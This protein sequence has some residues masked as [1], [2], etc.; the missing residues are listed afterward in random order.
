MKY[1][2]DANE[3]DNS[4]RNDENLNYN[5]HRNQNKLVII[6]LLYRIEN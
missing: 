4:K 5:T 6:A 3:G 1:I 2:W